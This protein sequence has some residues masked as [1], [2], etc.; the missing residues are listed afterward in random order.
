[1]RTTDDPCS[2]LILCSRLQCT[3][4]FLAG[5]KSCSRRGVELI[6]GTFSVSHRPRTGIPSRNEPFATHALPHC[7]H[8][9]TALF[10]KRASLN[11]E[12]YQRSCHPALSMTML[13]MNTNLTVTSVSSCINRRAKRMS[14]TRRMKS[15]TCNLQARTCPVAL[16]SHPQSRIRHSPVVHATRMSIRSWCRAP[17]ARG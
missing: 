15:R 14:D 9:E 8:E 10:P 1:M 2:H 6:F 7:V 16:D 3:I 13:F 5:D 17:G 4:W 11:S 12:K